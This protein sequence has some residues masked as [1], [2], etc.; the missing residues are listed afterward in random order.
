MG[1][2][3]LTGATIAYFDHLRASSLFDMESG[4]DRNH[5]P[6]DGANLKAS[7]DGLII[8]KTGESN[9]TVRYQLPRKSHTN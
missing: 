1:Y 6:V 8:E 5:H 7:L 9:L 3:S 4:C 2:P